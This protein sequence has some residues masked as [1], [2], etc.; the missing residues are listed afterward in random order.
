MRKGT[1]VENLN[2]V[3]ER[4]VTC[5]RA[6]GRDP[7]SVMLLA[8]SKTRPAV[9]LRAAY[10]AGQRHF[11]ENY[12]Q[13]ALEKLGE[14]ADLDICWHFIGPL[15]SNKTR[16]AA[17]AFHW[18]HSVDRLKIAQ[19]LSAQRPARMPPL[20]ICLQVNIDCEESKSGVAPDRV[21]ELAAAVAQLPNLK[22]RGLMAI[23]AARQDAAAQRQPFA[24]LAELLQQLRAQ[25]PEHPLDTLSMGM[26]GDMEAAIECGATI[27]RI[28]T[29]IFGARD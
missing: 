5:C 1:I 19:R 7:A 8:V 27:V 13:E 25:L 14:L 3:R 24:R 17:E 2:A 9:D 26:S 21:A 16:A 12:L 18:I 20:N 11:G 22:L 10:D 29:D 4:I 6:S 23:P 15:Q 28:G